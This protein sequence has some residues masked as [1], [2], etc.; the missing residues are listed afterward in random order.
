LRWGGKVWITRPGTWHG[1]Y[2]HEFTAA[3]VPKICT[4]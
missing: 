3:E 4:G 2:T 1:Y